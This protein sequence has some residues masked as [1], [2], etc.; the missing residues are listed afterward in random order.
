LFERVCPESTIIHTILSLIIRT[1]NNNRKKKKKKKKRSRSS[2]ISKVLLTGKTR[3]DWY[4]VAHH[5]VANLRLMCK[6]YNIG[7]N[8]RFLNKFR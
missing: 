1:A 7:Q 8:Y 4:L 5:V 3:C 2:E 6:R